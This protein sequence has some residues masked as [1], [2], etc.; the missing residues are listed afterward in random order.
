MNDEKIYKEFLRKHKLKSTKQR[1]LIFEFFMKSEDHLSAEAF[2][3][4]IKE[5]DPSIGQATVYRMLKLLTE[6]GIARK[7]EMGNGLAV[8]ERS[9]GRSHHD[10][11][12]CDRCFKTVEFHDADIERRQDEL[13]RRYGFTLTGHKMF[14]FGLC[15]DC[16]GKK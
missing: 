16:A 3:A 4:K 6:S 2:C 5:H 1:S 12:I 7:L 8:Y 15:P 14:L 11:L 9:A 13:A 10:H